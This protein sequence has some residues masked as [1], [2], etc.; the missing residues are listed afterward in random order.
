[1]IVDVNKK[2]T[3]EKDSN[4]SSLELME[5]VGALLFEEIKKLIDKKTKV[6][7]LVGKGN[8]GGD[9]LVLVR[10]LKEYDYKICLVEE[11]VNSK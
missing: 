7:L 8:N 4:F 2:K 9:A 3:N 5:K 10:L 1:M 6:L 11:E